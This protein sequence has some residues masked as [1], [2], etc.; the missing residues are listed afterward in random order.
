MERLKLNIEKFLKLDWEYNNK[1]ES[2]FTIAPCG[3]HILCHQTY[4][5][6]HNV[7]PRV[8]YHDARE[9]WTYLYEKQ[10]TVH[11]VRVGLLVS[12]GY[13]ERVH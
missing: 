1:E 10:E 4:I 2:F 8:T 6:V 9:L 11:E 3:A 5:L 13:L 12:N 7:A